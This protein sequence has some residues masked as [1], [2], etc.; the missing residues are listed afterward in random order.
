MPG[1][2]YWDTWQDVVGMLISCFSY[3]VAAW[4]SVRVIAWIVV[5][6]RSERPNISK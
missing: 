1:D 4:G 6:F 2:R 3:F 5:G